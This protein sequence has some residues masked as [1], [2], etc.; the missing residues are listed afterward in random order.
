[1]EKSLKFLR[2]Y[3]GPFFALAYGFTIFMPWGTKDYTDRGFYLVLF[4][5]VGTLA[6]GHLF[7]RMGD[8]K[9]KPSKS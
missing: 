2:T 3:F 1:M 4:Q 8:P 9:T 7:L 6:I 5:A